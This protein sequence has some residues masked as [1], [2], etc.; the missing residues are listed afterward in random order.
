M[1]KQ[2]FK[3]NNDNQ[4]IYKIFPWGKT[5]IITNDKARKRIEELESYRYLIW[6][7]RPPIFIFITLMVFIFGVFS[8]FLINMSEESIKA[9]MVYSIMAIYAL[10]SFIYYL[11]LKK[12]IKLLD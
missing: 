6:S 7:Y 4:L 11:K 3:R 5:Y 1:S 12:A 8:F 2:I 10:I 9:Y